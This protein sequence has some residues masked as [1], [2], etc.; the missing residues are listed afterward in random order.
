MEMGYQCLRVRTRAGNCRGGEMCE[1][2]FKK[3]LF[4][5][6]LYPR[7]KHDLN[8]LLAGRFNGRLDKRIAQRPVWLSVLPTNRPANLLGRQRAKPASA[9]FSA[10][11]FQYK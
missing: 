2:R 4:L 10:F 5:I 11:H 7:Y 1:V 6:K 9:R 8:G 3:G